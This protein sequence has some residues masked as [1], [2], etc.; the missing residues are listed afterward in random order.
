MTTGRMDKA[1]G[2]INPTWRIPM[3]SPA[4]ERGRNGLLHPTVDAAHPLPQENQ[5]L[6][7]AN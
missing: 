2:Q 5:N 6:T 7:V 4:T 3:M 1:G